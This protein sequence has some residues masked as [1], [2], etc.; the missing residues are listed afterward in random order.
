M[1][2]I[3]VP[4]PN[5]PGKQDIEIE[6]TINGLKQQLHYRVELFYWEDCAFPQ[7]D[8]AECIRQMLSRYDDDWT[9]YYIGA[10]TEEFVP[11]TFVKKGQIAIQRKMM[12]GEPV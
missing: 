4:I 12:L 11:I 7:I 1:A 10:P 5:L 8:R 2:Y 9:L 3:A 6:V